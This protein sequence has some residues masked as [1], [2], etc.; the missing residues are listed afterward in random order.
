ML[1]GFRGDVVK[2]GR[3][4]LEK[5]GV[6][7]TIEKKGYNYIENKCKNYIEKQGKACYQAVNHIKG[8][9]LIRLFSLF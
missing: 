3:K 9:Y 6:R 8:I 1:E 2:E 5:R 7:K 4:T